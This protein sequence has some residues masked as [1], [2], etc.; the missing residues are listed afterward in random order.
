MSWLAPGG[1]AAA[2]AVGAAV[3]W[4][5]GWRGLVP[6]FAFFVSG[7]LLTQLAERSAPRRTTRQ[8]IANGSVAAVAALLGAW[9]AAA[10]AIAAA[11]ADTWATELGAFSPIAPRLITTGARVTRGAS[12]GITALGTAGGIAGAA[13]IASLAVWLE[14]RDMAPGLAHPEH[15]HTLALL[16]GAGVLG[17][18]ADSVLGATVQGKYEC[19]A[20]DARFE[21]GNR[22]CHEP[23]RLTRGWRWL[24]ND[25][26]N[27]AATL[28]GAAVAVLGS[29]YWP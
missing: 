18:L 9:P 16:T 21:S 10:G 1:L 14:P 13:I 26:V 22:V 27:L 23:V 3:A 5:F 19:P 24:D 4:G 8:V 7:S 2:L 29:R 15:T 28:V 6:L 25:G 12:G 17:M 11:T 20:C